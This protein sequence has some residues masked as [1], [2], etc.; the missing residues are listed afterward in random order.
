[1][2]HPFSAGRL[3]QSGSSLPPAGRL[4]DWDQRL[5]ALVERNRSR[6]YAYGSHDCL[7]WAAAVVK[8]VTG[9]D[10]GRGH[11]GKYKSAAGAARHLRKLGFDSPE[12]L[13]DSLFDRKP[14]GFA[15][16]GDLVTASDGIPAVCMGA[17]AL[18]V[19][20]DRL[21][22]SPASSGSPGAG[23]AGLVPVPREQWVKAWAVGDHHSGKLKPPRKPKAA[24]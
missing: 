4:P 9:K 8:A 11:R 19:G 13:L 15:Q 14:A 17:V 2:R 18:S 23:V 16:R 6:P 22:T 3:P 24:R 12:A 21:T 7:L 1:M 5:A 10:H 20:Q